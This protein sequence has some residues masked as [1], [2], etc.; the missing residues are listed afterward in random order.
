MN[1]WKVVEKEQKPIWDDALMKE[2]MPKRAYTCHM[3][4]S[5]WGWVWLVFFILA[6]PSIIVG[7]IFEP[8]ARGILIFALALAVIELF[9]VPYCMFHRDDEYEYLKKSDAQKRC[10][11]LNR[12]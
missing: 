11:Y 8:T 10:D 3:N 9:S 5:V 4:N 1:D 6:I 7:I 2:V 12:R